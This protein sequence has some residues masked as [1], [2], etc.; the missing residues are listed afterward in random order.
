[1]IDRR[2]ILKL[3]AAA[4]SAGVLGE[5]RLLARRRGGSCFSAAPGSSGRISFTRRSPADIG[6]DAESRPAR[7]ESEHRR[8]RARRGDPR[9]SLAAQRLRQSRRQEVGRGHRYRHQRVV[10]ARRRRGAQGLR[11]R[12]IYISS[13][14]VFLPVPDRGHPGGW[15]GAAHRHAAAGSAE[16][17]RDQGAERAGSPRRHARAAIS[18]SGPATSSVPA[19]P[20]IASPTGR[21]ASRAAAR[22]W[23]RDARP[24]SSSTSTCA[25]WPSGWSRHSRTATAGT[26]NVV[27]PATKQTFS[28]FLEGLRPLATAPI[29]FTWIEDYEWLKRYPLRK[30]RRRQHAGLTYAI[31][32]VMPD[33]DDL[34]HT[35]ISN[36]KAIA[37]GPDVPAAAD[38]RARHA[39]L[40]RI[41]RRARGAQEAA[42]LRPDR[43]RRAR[44]VDR[45][46][47]EDRLAHESAFQ[48]SVFGVCLRKS[49]R[50]SRIST[51]TRSNRARPGR[52]RPAHRRLVTPGSTERP[53]HRMFTTRR[54]NPSLFVNR[55]ISSRPHLLQCVARSEVAAAP[56]DLPGP[57]PGP[58]AR[59]A[60]GAGGGG[61]GFARRRSCTSAG[62]VRGD[63]GVTPPR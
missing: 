34:G 52:H 59:P 50:M 53:S 5:S 58:P 17:R 33:G 25:T 31:P 45:V 29:T 15:A 63:L 13:T 46:E 38:D 47:E 57:A 43:R 55:L 23:C 37:A 1:M 14:G 24:T 27:G 44:D 16:L 61:G 39:G 60:G 51:P 4:L 56:P 12:F 36:R 28:Q 3:G 42:A 8:L 10:D 41:R 30:R 48:P 2:H 40:A 19:T 11:R 62:K 6:R 18:S 20:R 49:P 21:C 26:F 54:M 9:R 7:A 22:C 32:W 35:Q